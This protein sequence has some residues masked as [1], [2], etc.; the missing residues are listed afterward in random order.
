[1]SPSPGVTQAQM[2]VIYKITWPNGE[3]YVGRDLTDS[4]AY[5]GSPDKRTIEFDFPTREAACFKVI[6]NASIQ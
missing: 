3:I 6:G 1:M 2:K 5:F 4:I